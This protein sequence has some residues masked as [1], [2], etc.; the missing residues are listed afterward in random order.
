M[1]NLFESLTSKK[2]G[3]FAA[4]AA[5]ILNSGADPDVV[6]AGLV[7]ALLSYVLPQALVDRGKALA[8]AAVKGA[9]AKAPDA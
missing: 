6:V 5:G 1:K 9:E 4:V 8:G 3:A 7:G 2:L